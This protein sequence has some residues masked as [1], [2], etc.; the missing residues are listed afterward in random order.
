MLHFFFGLPRFVFL[1]APLCYL[2]FQL[3]IIAAS[4]LMVIVYAGAASDSLD[5]DQFAPAVALSPFVLGRNL[6]ER[7]RP[8][9]FAADAGDADRPQARPVQRHRKRRPAA[10]AIISITRSFARI[11][12]FSGLLVL[13]LLVGISAVGSLHVAVSDPRSAGAEYRLG[14]LQSADRR[15]RDRGWRTRRAKLRISVRLG[16]EMPASHLSAERAIT[17]DPVAQLVDDG[18]HVRSGSEPAGD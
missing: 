5:R 12:I 4:G 16:L 3:N 17:G 10:R 15:R 13:A 7:A 1:T 6:R 11:L 9:H 8:V 14:D 2:M 18:R